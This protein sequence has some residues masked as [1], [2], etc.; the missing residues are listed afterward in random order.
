MYS[1]LLISSGR[2]GAQKRQPAKQR[3][4]GAWSE[5]DSWGTMRPDANVHW[6]AIRLAILADRRLPACVVERQIKKPAAVLS[7]QLHTGLSVQQ[8]AL[9]RPPVNLPIDIFLWLR[10]Y[11]NLIS[12]SSRIRFRSPTVS[13]SHTRGELTSIRCRESHPAISPPY[14]PER[15]HQNLSSIAKRLWLPSFLAKAA[16][17]L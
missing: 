15:N 17:I 8:V 2:C 12:R 6:P 3:G 4:H 14:C 16:Y 9:G 7:N 11:A 10:W 1:H 5:S 13:A